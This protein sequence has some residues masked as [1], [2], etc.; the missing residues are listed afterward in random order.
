VWFRVDDSF[1]DHP[2]AV[3]LS[4]NAVA[5]WTRTGAWSGRQLTDGRVPLPMVEQFGHGPDAAKVITAELVDHRLWELPDDE[6]VQ[7]HDWPD[8][9]PTREQVLSRRE[10]DAK[11]RRR[12]LDRYRDPDTG[13][14][15]NGVTDP[16]TDDVT[17]GVTD[18]VT[19]GV[20][21]GQVTPARPDP[22]RRGGVQV[23]DQPPDRNAPEASADDDRTALEHQ[24]MAFM[25][26]A[27][28]PVNRAQ[29]AALIDTTL[30]GR[31]PRDPGAYIVATLRKDP[32]AA[33]RRVAT[34]RQPPPARDVLPNAARPGGPA[35]DVAARAADARALLAAKTNPAPPPEA[36]DAAL[37]DW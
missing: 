17:H 7:F 25:V 14:V 22:T 36:A 6:A 27:G 33:L 32:A 37:P 23:G 26:G 5:L 11:R 31:K 10:A 19:H 21:D 30:A 16:V 28:H 12:H 18:P 2:K 29:A 15:T 3:G 13:R 9:N 8:W 1:Y 35:A 24:V 20:T 4:D 34:S